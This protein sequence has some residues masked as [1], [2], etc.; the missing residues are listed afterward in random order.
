MHGNVK[1]MAGILGQ[2]LT[3]GTRQHQDLEIPIFDGS[4]P[5]WWVRRCERFFELYRIGEEQ[6]VT[7]ATAY[8]DDTADAWYQSWRQS[9][10]G[11]VT[12]TKFSNELCGRFGERNLADTVEEFNKLKQQGSVEDYLRR[13]EELKALIGAAHPSLPESYFVSSFISGLRDDLRFVVK[14][15]GPVSVRQAAKKARLQEVTWEAVFKKNRPWPQGG[16]TVN[17]GGSSYGGKQFQTEH[18]R[19]KPGK[20]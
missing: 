14:M 18:G 11:W 3:G 15:L 17:R 2:D 1:T 19:N 12:W 13:F 8:L 20:R 7:M 4:K 9:E 5:R 16:S 10:G 6:R